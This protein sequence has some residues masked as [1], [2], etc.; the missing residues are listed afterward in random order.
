M[1]STLSDTLETDPGTDEHVDADL[2]CVECGY[3]LRTLAYSASCPECGT[4]VLVSSR[5][6]HLSAAPTQWLR[7]LVHGAWW[8][9]VSV[10]LALP[11]VYLGVAVSCY[12]I[13][14]LTITQ[15]GRV[16]PSLDRS[17]RLAARWA[18]VAGAVVVVAMILGA[19]IMVAATDQRFAS[20][21]NMRFKPGWAGG[22]AGEFPVFDMLFL[23]G[24][25]VYVLG[26]ISTWRYLRVLAERVPDLELADGWRGLGRC[27]Y[28]SV[29]GLVGVCGA[30]YVLVRTGIVP[31]GSSS[32]MLPLVVGLLFAVVLLALWVATLRVA[33]L[34]VRVME[35]ERWKAGRFQP[36]T[37]PP[38]QES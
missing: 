21:W 25:A 22:P 23:I 3:N 6:D 31:G 9:R 12:G 24:H 11:I 30:A 8:L 28:A 36:P 18:T 7:A 19:L 10:V 32:F 38:D 14:V 17:Y 26:L 1:S 2:T 20:N 4:A 35:A 16:E 33:G 5:G 37:T 13:W 27:W 15:Q 29:F 34:Q